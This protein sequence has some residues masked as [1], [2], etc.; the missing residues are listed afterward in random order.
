MMIPIEKYR[1]KDLIIDPLNYKI[2]QKLLEFNIFE[3]PTFKNRSK[4]FA[5]KH[6]K[7]TA[8]HTRNRD[9]LKGID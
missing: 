4:Y 5:D 8:L 7:I 6:K 1:S 3:N 9:F 2:I